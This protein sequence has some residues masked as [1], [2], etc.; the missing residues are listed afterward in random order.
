MMMMMM[1]C[2]ELFKPVCTL[3]MVSDILVYF[4]Q[5]KSILEIC[6]VFGQYA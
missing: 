2:L 4:F 1:R 6:K 3:A 5:L